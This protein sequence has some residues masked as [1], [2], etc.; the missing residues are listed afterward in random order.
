MQEIVS[1]VSAAHGAKGVLRF[2]D[3]HYPPLVNSAAETATAL[4]AAARLVGQD[5]VSADASKVMGS[6]DFAWMLRDRPGC[7][8]LIGN[9]DAPGSCMVHNPHYDFNDEIL[10]LGASYWVE[11][12]ERALPVAADAT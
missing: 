9:G 12:V 1:G 4:E 3:D 6:E 10:A 5:R 8:M 2:A 7:Y 11:L